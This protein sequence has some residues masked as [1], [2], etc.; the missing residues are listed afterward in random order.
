MFFAFADQLERLPPGKRG[1]RTARELRKLAVRHQR[2]LLK[3]KDF[4]P[5]IH[6]SKKDLQS[7]AKAGTYADSPELL[8]LE[9][10]LKV[11]VRLLISSNG[12]QR[13]C[14]LQPNPEDRNSDWPTIRLGFRFVS[15]N[16]AHNHYYSMRAFSKTYD[17][18]VTPVENSR[19][20]K[21]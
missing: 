20:F 3:S 18:V 4:D 14:W 5:V 19:I 8:A 2:L 17:F 11:N 6:R 16:S 15:D 13:W 7:M 9:K 1:V 21:L 12:E 10:E